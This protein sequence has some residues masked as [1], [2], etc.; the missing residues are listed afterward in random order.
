[1]VSSKDYFSFHKFCT[2]FLRMIKSI[3]G[4]LMTKIITCMKNYLKFNECV[5]C[6]NKLKFNKRTLVIEFFHLICLHVRTK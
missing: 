5:P 2:R 3:E 6:F 4:Y 1:M